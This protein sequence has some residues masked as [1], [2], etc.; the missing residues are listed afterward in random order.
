M[1]E[2]PRGYHVHGGGEVC[3]ICRKEVK[4]SGSRYTEAIMIGGQPVP[5]ARA[6]AALAYNPDGEFNKWIESPE[7]EERGIGIIKKKLALANSGNLPP[8]AAPDDQSPR[9][10]LADHTDAIAKALKE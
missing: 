8:V 2:W 10:V 5:E 6:E 7:V 1:S 3:P 9:K 4:P